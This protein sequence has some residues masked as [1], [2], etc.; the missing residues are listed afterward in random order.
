M[1]A[2]AAQLGSRLQ[3]LQASLASV[4]ASISSNPNDTCSPNGSASL[5]PQLQSI[6]DAACTLAHDAA[7]AALGW[8]S[9]CKIQST[10]NHYANAQAATVPA[11]SLRYGGPESG[12]A[13][14]T[15]TLS[16]A[17]QGTSCLDPT[18]LSAVAV[19]VN[20][21]A[22][23]VSEAIAGYN[24]CQAATKT[25]KKA[26]PM[27]PSQLA[28]P[29]TSRPV[30]RRM[31]GQ[32]PTVTAQNISSQAVLAEST[33]GGAVAGGLLGALIGLIADAPGDGA[34]IGGAIGGV[35]GFIGGYN[36]NAALAASDQAAAQSQSSTGAAGS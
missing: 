31:T 10:A 36:Q 21:A 11:C 15:V 25:I 35:L 24:A 20:G 4:K 14:G 7:L 9:Q 23:A 6:S 27:L 32:I 33:V 34:L 8:A 29:S 17:G 5:V 3:S 18:Y 13:Y 22:Q 26:R 16:G 30:V 12:D 1:T 28:A 2:T 19:Q